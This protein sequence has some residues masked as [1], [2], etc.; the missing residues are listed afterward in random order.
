MKGSIMDNWSLRLCSESRD[1]FAAGMEM[2][3]SQAPGKI[4]KFYSIIDGCALA[5]LWGWPKGDS[6]EFEWVF[7]ERRYRR[8]EAEVNGETTVVG[9]FDVS[10][11]VAAVASIQDVPY[12]M[13]A[14]AATDFAWNWLR[15]GAQYPPKDDIWHDVSFVA[16]FM[17]ETD[18]WGHVWSN[19]YGIIGIRP[20]W[21]LIGK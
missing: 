9:G 18:Y 16:G 8:I 14:S 11:R 20:D 13:D 2:A 21:A 6:R 15:S 17:L 4:A 1:H 3:F 12:H 5:F 19:H 10:E 7:A